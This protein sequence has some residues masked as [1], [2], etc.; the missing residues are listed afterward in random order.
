MTRSRRPS[1]RPAHLVRVPAGRA[2]PAA[3]SATR[4]P[5]TE[6]RDRLEAR[7]RMTAREAPRHAETLDV[8]E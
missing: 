5:V 4:P 2:G 7:I 3:A 8:V 6:R 1:A